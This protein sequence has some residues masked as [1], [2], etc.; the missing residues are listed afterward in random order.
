[1]KPALVLSNHP[2]PWL[3]WQMGGL[4]LDK[5]VRAL[6]GYLTAATSW[7]VRDRFARLSQIATVLSLERCAEIADYCGADAG[8]ALTWR[9]APSEVRR[10]MGLR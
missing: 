3:L 7:S 6:V 2:C 1:M 10:V 4:L 5:E 8:G 9:L